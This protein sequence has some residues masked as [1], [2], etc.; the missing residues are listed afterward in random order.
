M[1]PKTLK[2]SYAAPE[3]VF[4]SA[5][6]Q[7][8]LQLKEQ[9]LRDTKAVLRAASKVLESEGWKAMLISNRGGVAASGESYGYFQKTGYLTMFVEFTTGVLRGGAMSER[10]SDGA[11]IMV[12]YRQEILMHRVVGNNI[13]LPVMDS[14]AL[15]KEIVRLAR[16]TP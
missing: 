11:L 9:F 3:S 7:Q 10:S 12:Q 2:A 1:K 4:I 15:A 14:D 13:F 16:K 6:N 8:G 5:Y